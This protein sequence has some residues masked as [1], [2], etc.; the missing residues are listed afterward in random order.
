MK[1][2][3]YRLDSHPVDEAVTLIGSA[4]TEIGLSDNF[5]PD[6]WTAL[7]GA[8]SLLNAY[9]IEKGYVRNDRRG[10]FR[11]R[12]H[13]TDSSGHPVR[14]TYSFE[15]I[16]KSI[17]LLLQAYMNLREYKGREGEHHLS[18]AMDNILS[19]CFDKLGKHCAIT[20]SEL[21]F[22]TSTP[23]IELDFTS[24]FEHEI[25]YGYKYPWRDDA[26]GD[27]LVDF[28]SE[29]RSASEIETE[30]LEISEEP[31]FRETPKGEDTSLS[32]LSEKIV[33]QVADT[34]S[35]LNAP[36]DPDAT[37][38]PDNFSLVSLEDYVKTHRLS[39]SELIKIAVTGYFV[40]RN[41]KS[42][43]IC[44]GGFYMKKTFQEKTAARFQYP[45]SCDRCTKTECIGKKRHSYYYFSNKQFI[46]PMVD[47][48]QTPASIKNDKQ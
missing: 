3:Y 22:I 9:Q 23:N 2:T 32:A 27:V 30:T 8:L 28:S 10:I 47:S 48:K 4:L 45:K 11:F 39:T 40:K 14:Y 5:V 37:L 41:D 33:T 43:V 25:T 21:R 36:S 42:Y 34:D 16:H 46:K 44:P 6:V 17:L 19:A 20:F 1:E 13:E 26:S 38:Y 24:L 7:G 31:P 12:G 29:C 15:K 35:S 18:C